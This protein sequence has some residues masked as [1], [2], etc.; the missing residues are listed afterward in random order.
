MVK[1]SK[2]K[3][4]PARSRAAHRP[5]AHLRSVVPV[6]LFSK[7][8]VQALAVQ[9][10]ASDQALHQTPTD[11]VAAEAALLLREAFDWAVWCDQR[12]QRHAEPE[13]ERRYYERVAK[14]C[15]KLLEALGVDPDACRTAPERAHDVVALASFRQLVDRMTGSQPPLP[16]HLDR[17]CRAAWNDGTARPTDDTGHC[18]Y[19]QQ[20]SFLIDRLPR[21]LELLLALARWR[22]A[23]LERDPKNR[24]GRPNRL[25]GE[26]FMILAGAHGRIFG[27]KPVTRGKAGLPIGGSITWARAVIRLGADRI[28]A[29]ISDVTAN[30]GGRGGPS[31]QT[32]TFDGAL[33]EVIASYAAR[34]ERF[35]S[36]SDRTLSDLLDQGWQAWTRSRSP[37]SS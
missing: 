36:M 4:T 8:D 34:F 2:R 12:A 23:R 14:Q 37:S 20:A 27:R 26:L 13:R 15:E 3:D 22:A 33:P 18:L 6:D 17:L 24:G 5:D 19:R 7:H 29:S 35:A 30:P 32:T 1:M 16:D 31:D 25:R 10:K 9:A 11:A 28:R 21:T